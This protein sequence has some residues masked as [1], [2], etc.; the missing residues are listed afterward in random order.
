MDG[1]QNKR[2]PKPQLWLSATL[3][4]SPSTLTTYLESHGADLGESLFP[5]FL[6][7]GLCCLYLL[8]A[9]ALCSFPSLHTPRQPLKL[10][11]FGTTLS[12]PLKAEQWNNQLRV[13]GS[14]KIPALS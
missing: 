3:T 6:R 5:L 1:D 14:P 8:S 7:K 4:G 12:L 11:V 9:S 13:Q 2:A 10:L